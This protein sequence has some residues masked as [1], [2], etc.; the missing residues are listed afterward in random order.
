MIHTPISLCVSAFI[1]PKHSHPQVAAQATFFIRCP[2][3]KAWTAI[4]H[5][6]IMFILVIPVSYINA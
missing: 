5:A 4:I 2:Y 3:K 1:L 6:K